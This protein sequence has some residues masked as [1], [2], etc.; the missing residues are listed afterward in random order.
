MAEAEFFV[1]KR[2]PHVLGALVVLE[3]TRMGVP[4][5]KG[6]VVPQSDRTKNGDNIW[7]SGYY[8]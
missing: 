1:R 3:V 6:R 2:G 4:V 7:C 8:I 5:V